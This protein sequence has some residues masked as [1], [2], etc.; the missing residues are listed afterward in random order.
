MKTENIP[1]LMKDR[2]F[3]IQDILIKQ[4][5][6]KKF[7]NTVVVI[8]LLKVK[9][10]EKILKEIRPKQHITYKRAKII[11][12]MADLSKTMEARRKFNKFFKVLERK[13]LSTKTLICNKN[14]I[15]ELK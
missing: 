9:K 4:Y 2:H 14:V 11:E 13:Q 15:Q 8:K 5:H 3:Q 10:E 6:T 1:N 7:V 12:L